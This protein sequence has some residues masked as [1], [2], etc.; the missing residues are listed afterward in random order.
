MLEG[1]QARG[2][3]QFLAELLRVPMEHHGLGLV[4][5][6]GVPAGTND[7]VQMRERDSGYAFTQRRVSTGAEAALAGWMDEGWMAGWMKDG[8]MAGSWRLL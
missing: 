3:D 8:W 4:Q 2:T 7:S 6:V 1:R 5:T